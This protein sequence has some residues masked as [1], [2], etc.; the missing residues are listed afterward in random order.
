[1]TLNTDTYITNCTYQW[2]SS[3]KYSHVIVN[4][5]LIFWYYH[6]NGY[7]EKIICNSIIHSYIILNTHIYTNWSI[8]YI[9]EYIIV[10]LWLTHMEILKKKLKMRCTI[11]PEIFL[12]HC[13]HLPITP[14]VALPPK[15]ATPDNNFATIWRYPCK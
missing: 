1:M 11:F 13:H 10:S 12:L 6:T 7:R 2:N 14:I 15:A 8:T 9:T 5:N 3:L 4:T